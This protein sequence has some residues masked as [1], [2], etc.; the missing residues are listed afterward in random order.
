MNWK[1]ILS[2][3]WPDYKILEDIESLDNKFTIF[4]QIGIV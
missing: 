4:Q 2:V 3:T 1:E